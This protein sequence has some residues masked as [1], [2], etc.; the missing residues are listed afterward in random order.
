MK[1]KG[2]NFIFAL[3]IWKIIFSI[4]KIRF[5]INDFS[6]FIRLYPQKLFGL[7]QCEYVLLWQHLMSIMRQP[8]PKIPINVISI[9]DGNYFYFLYPK[10]LSLV[11]WIL[12]IQEF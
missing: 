6:L 5:Q 2:N 8:K 7:G 1:K 3:I 11:S 9:E 10:G 4:K 12:Q